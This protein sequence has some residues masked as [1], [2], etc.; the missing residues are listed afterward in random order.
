MPDSGRKMSN[1]GNER[2]NGILK[3]VSSMI[4]KICKYNKTSMTAGYSVLHLL[5]DG[6]CALAMFG[7]FIP[8]DN[9]CLYILLY[10]F[11]AFALQMPLGV[12]LDALNADRSEKRDYAFAAA[13]LGV[14]CTILGA[15]T[16]PVILGIGNAL[17][18]T[19]G[20]VGVI[21]ADRAERSPANSSP[22]SFPQDNPSASGFLP[23]DNAS[24]P[25]K[26]QSGKWYGQG[27]GIFVAPGALGLYLG[28][29]AAK[30]GV[31]ETG[32]LCVSALM[33]LL[34]AAIWYMGKLCNK[35]EAERASAGAGQ[36]EALRREC[37]GKESAELECTGKESGELEC[38]RKG[39]AELECARKESADQ[40]CAGK[41]SGEREYVRK[42]AANQ[43]CAGKVYAKP[44]ILPVLF[45]MAVVILRSHIGMTV[46][47]PW[48]TGMAAG[49]LA[50]LAVVGGKM[51]GG[52]AAAKW[53]LY[54]TVVVS[55][56]LAALCYL[57]SA[58]MPFGLAASFLFNMTMPLTLYWMICRM[59]ERPGFAFGLLTFALFL[60]FLPGYFGLVQ[61][62]AGNIAGCAG[63][64]LSLLLLAAMMG[65]KHVGGC[66]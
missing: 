56:A 52:F 65:R 6:A 14:F 45:C 60:G 42:G 55:L 27:L 15:F 58:V 50:V 3:K 30:N 1:Q 64:I 53:G 17:F 26:P 28:T 40:E 13:A 48:K 12:V 37:A 11:C 22:E 43:E 59:P 10:N 19:G 4:L 2:G 44:E 51:A 31:W 23:A 18:H 46:G 41:E 38:A 25:E 49:I 29:M 16:H 33:I 47:F 8:E 7:R 20:G 54:K 36:R 35:E 5:V 62:V 57:F 39:S 32:F 21:K 34:C 63:S 9:G 66:D 61:T 24:L